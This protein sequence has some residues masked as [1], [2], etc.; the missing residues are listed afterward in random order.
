MQ[1]LSRLSLLLLLGFLSVGAIIFAS[2]SRISEAVIS[3]TASESA[4]GENVEEA[5]N[6]DTAPVQELDVTHEPI[7]T[8]PSLLH[9][10]VPASSSNLNLCRLMLSASILEY[11]TPVLVDWAAEGVFNAS[12][13]HLA[14]VTGIL[15]YLESFPPE[16]DD[17]LVL[18]LDGF[19]VWLQLRAEILIQRYA[20][21]IRAS[22]EALVDRYG[23]ET[24]LEHDMRQSVVIG[25]DKICWPV[26]DRRPACWAVPETPFPKWSFGPA[27]DH[28]MDH[29]RPRWLNS[30]TLLGPLK[31]LRELF[32]GT[33][34]TIERNYD[35]ENLDKDSDQMYM[36]DLWAEQEY[37]RA[38]LDTTRN[39]NDQGPADKFLPKIP[40]DRKTE[41]HIVLDYDSELFQASAGYRPF[42]AWFKYDRPAARK[43]EQQGMTLPYQIELPSDI[44]DSRP[45]FASMD[46]RPKKSESINIPV[47]K[48]WKDLPLGTNVVS[49]QIFPIFHLTGDKRFRDLWWDRLWF[50]PWAESL[51][52]AAVRQPRKMITATEDGR[53]WWN[54]EDGNVTNVA[55]GDRGGAWSDRREWLSWDELCSPYEDEL[56][57]K[58]VQ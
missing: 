19:D 41:Y 38:L 57:R 25:T 21:L 33:Q 36:A 12:M 31:D 47:E 44:L 1:A 23:K 8:G 35:E 9:L 55:R 34:E 53:Q 7:P 4:D 49:K 37:S 52:K 50:F 28:D 10:V 13:S 26:D 56:F 20:R 18:I 5:S 43:P 58:A 17:D 24:V 39:I 2:S 30:G 29:T 22:N 32:N 3:F 16:Q 11:P 42:L 45:P 14:K 15:R 46:E 51:L 6:A 54:A 40:T 48:G 27:T